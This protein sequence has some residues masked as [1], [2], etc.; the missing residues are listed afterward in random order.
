MRALLATL[1]LIASVGGA[2][3]GCANYVDGSQTDPAPKVT[4]CFDKKCEETTLDFVCGNIHGTQKGYANGWRFYS[5]A[6]TKT[7][8]VMRP[9]VVPAKD[10]P[11]ISCQPADTEACAFPF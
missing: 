3:A 5:D 2:W 6:D 1:A 10:Y 4:L 9:T 11:K 7:V 8:T